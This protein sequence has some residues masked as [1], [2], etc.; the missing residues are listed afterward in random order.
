MAFTQVEVTGTVRDTS[1]NPMPYIRVEFALS[2]NLCDKKQ[3]GQSLDQ[4][5]IPGSLGPPSLIAT[6]FA[7]T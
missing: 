5:N 3:D 2:Q 6:R 4:F 1:G 7:Q